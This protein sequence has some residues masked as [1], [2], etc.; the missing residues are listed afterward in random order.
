MT[1]RAR[2]AQLLAILHVV[3]I[4]A[5]QTLPQFG[6]EHL[7]HLGV[8]RWLQSV[9]LPIKASGAAAL[10]VTRRRPAAS[11]AVGAALVAYYASA[12][13]F[14]VLT[15]EPTAQALPAALYGALAAAIV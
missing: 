8:P 4:V 13:T 9:L 6:G 5:T 10:L 11:S 7:D 14:H 12:V 2:A 3:D 1:S 15:E